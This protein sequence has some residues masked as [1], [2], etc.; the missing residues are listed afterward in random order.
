[1]GMTV[2]KSYQFVFMQENLAI[3]VKIPKY[4][5]IDLRLRRFVTT[6]YEIAKMKTYRNVE[7][8]LV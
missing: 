6:Q 7:K 5:Y 3:S 8:I 4:M 2:G 1:M